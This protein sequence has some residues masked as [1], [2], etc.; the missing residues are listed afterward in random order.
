MEESMTLVIDSK[1]LPTRPPISLTLSTIV[2][3]DH[4]HAPGWVWGFV[5]CFLAILHVAVLVQVR[6]EE[7]GEVVITR[8]AR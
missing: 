2:A 8:R 5:M 4:W 3:L 1:Q 6:K 7:S